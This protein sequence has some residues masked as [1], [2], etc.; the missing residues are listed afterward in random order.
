MVTSDFNE[1]IVKIKNLNI[2]VIDWNYEDLIMIEKFI[3]LRIRFE[4][5]YISLIDIPE[6]DKNEI[7]IKQ[8][9]T[10]KLIDLK[11]FARNIYRVKENDLKL[12]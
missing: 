2:Y 1:A 9:N 12:I 11:N 4:L 5:K 8:K 7:E 3:A 6:I 10:L